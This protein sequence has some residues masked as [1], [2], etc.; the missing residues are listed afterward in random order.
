MKQKLNTKSGFRIRQLAPLLLL[1]L[2]VVLVFLS[3]FG[4]ESYNRLQE[5]EAELRNQRA[6]NEA[7]STYVEEMRAEVVGLQKDDRVL[8]K[9]ARNEL[10]MV[11]SN[12]VL[13]VFREDGVVEE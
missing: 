7:I 4:D 9:T 12:E 5:L 1:T 10:G 11:R 6:D 8:E 13:F 3:F 2:S